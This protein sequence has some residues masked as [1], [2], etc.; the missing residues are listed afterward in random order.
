MNILGTSAGS[1]GATNSIL[2]VT[3]AILILIA[4]ILGTIV[5]R[6]RRVI[7]TKRKNK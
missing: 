2:N 6:K 4:I 1:A 7:K 3:L 5:F